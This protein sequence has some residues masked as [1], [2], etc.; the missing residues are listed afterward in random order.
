VLDGV[1]FEVPSGGHV[2]LLGATGAGKSS[3]VNLIPRF[4]DVTG[5][6]IRIDGIDV[7]ELDLGQLRSR[8]GTVLQETTLFSGTIRENIAY[9]RPEATSEEV[10][11]AAKAAQVH[12]FIMAMPGGYQATVEAGGANLSGGQRQRIAIARALL[13]EPDILILD[14]STSAVDLETEGR[15]QD[16]LETLMDGRTTFVVA[17][18]ISSVLAA[19]QI[20]VL[21]D[22]R[23]AARGNHAELLATSPIYREIYQSQLGGIA[24]PDLIGEPGG[25]E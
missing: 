9:G 6:S 5:G 22:G 10:I 21:D 14:D 25:G 23:V 1:T 12:D 3:L 7:R 16:A 24:E 11:A 20:L 17:Q 4:Y 8:I 2:A 18:R 13:V 15:I 19:D